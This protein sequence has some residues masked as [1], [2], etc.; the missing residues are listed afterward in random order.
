MLHE[1]KY[2]L[3]GD[4]VIPM[5][6]RVIIEVDNPKV[7]RLQVPPDPHRGTLSD[8]ISSGGSFDDVDWSPDGTQ[9]AFV[10]TSRD[11]KDEKFRIADAATGAVREVF[12]EKVPT[13]YESGRSAIDWRYLPKSNEIIW[14]SERDNWGH[15]YLYDATTGKLKNQITKGEWVVS[16]LYKVDEKKRVL[17]FTVAGREAENPYFNQLYKVNFDGSHLG[18]LTPETG[19]NVVTFSPGEDYFIDTYSKP[20][21]AAGKRIA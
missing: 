7:I 11:H 6:Q 20:D 3:P 12:E 15:L 9:L 13:Q 2:P 5:I 21:V 10:S 1:W 19:N 4:P 18:L 14:Y 16:R 17:Y 8:D